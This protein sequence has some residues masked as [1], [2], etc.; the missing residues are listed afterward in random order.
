[1]E[2]KPNDEN[3]KLMYLVL[4]EIEEIWSDIN[5]IISKYQ[6]DIEK[7]LNSIDLIRKVE[8]TLII[9]TIINVIILFIVFVIFL[10]RR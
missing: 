9:L 2:K 6:K 7:I 4:K 10:I 8:K 1:M 5:K 3:L